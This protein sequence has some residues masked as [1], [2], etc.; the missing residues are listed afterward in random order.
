MKR[1]LLSI[2]LILLV[3]VIKS[4][5]PVVSFQQEIKGFDGGVALPAQ[6]NFVISGNISVIITR[7][8]V[9]I[10]QNSKMDKM[11]YSS[12]WLRM[13]DDRGTSFSIPVNKM[14]R[15]NEE[16]TFKLNFYTGAEKEDHLQIVDMLQ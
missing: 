2:F 8:E 14:L 13:T 1:L 16:Y 4:Q 11:F 9:E 12:S 7:V 15:S 6:K 5:V 10:Y 3:S